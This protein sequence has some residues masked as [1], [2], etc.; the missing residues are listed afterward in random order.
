M[1]PYLPLGL[2]AVVVLLLIDGFFRDEV[3]LASRGLR[4]EQLEGWRVAFA[5]VV[6]ADSKANPAGPRWTWTL[7]GSG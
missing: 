2:I 6:G 7:G 4:V 1:D 3:D 5:R